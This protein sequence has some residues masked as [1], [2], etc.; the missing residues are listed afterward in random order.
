MVL[1]CCPK[2]VAKGCVSA[3]LDHATFDHV[4][5]DSRVRMPATPYVSAP[6]ALL[7]WIIRAMNDACCTRAKNSIHPVHCQSCYR[8]R[9]VRTSYYRVVQKKRT[10]LLSTSL[11]WP[12]VA[13]C[14]RA[15]TFS[16]LSSI[17]FAQPCSVILVQITKDYRV[18]NPN[19][20][21]CCRNPIS[22]IASYQGLWIWHTSAGQFPLITLSTVHQYSATNYKAK[23]RLRD[24]KLT[25]ATGASSRKLVFTF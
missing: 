9:P 8:E 11:A 20:I 7:S 1:F 6:I 10:V 17:S 13:G 4:Y 19:W 15:E 14:S 18:N 3:G 16:Q 24:S 5:L 22:Y 21:Y 12:A 2:N 23:I 25:L